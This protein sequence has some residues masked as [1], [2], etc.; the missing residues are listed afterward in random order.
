MRPIRAVSVFVASPSDVREERDALER[1]VQELNLT[2]AAGGNA[3]LE[4]V[5]W[6]THVRPGIAADPQQ[7][8]NNQA[9]SSHDIVIGIFWGRVGTPT[10]RAG[11]GTLEELEMAIARW[12]ADQTSVEVMIYF[13]EDGI[14]PFQSNAD[15]LAKLTQFRESLPKRGILYKTVAGKEFESLVRVDIARAVMTIVARNAALGDPLP[16]EP[17]AVSLTDSNPT[18]FDE[19]DGFEDLLLQSNADLEQAT[20]TIDRIGQLAVEQTANFEKH[21]AE[22][23]GPNRRQSLDGIAVGLQNYAERLVQET[24][25]LSFYQERAL[26]ALA[27]AILMASEDGAMTEKDR[28]GLL[29][30]VQQSTRTLVTFSES[31][32]TTRHILSNMPR[33][34]RSLNVSKRN[35]GNAVDSLLSKL[36]A[37]QRMQDSIEDALKTGLKLPV[38]ER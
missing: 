25:Q 24:G 13:K 12:Q 33:V 4:L 27:R 10:P 20:A 14:S 5:R 31:L 29:P 34:T 21:T 2:V 11:S 37:A 26:S 3:R 22:L 28:A 19:D 1:V 23:S 15:Q 32:K 16:A 35:A 17:P 8:I 7:T 30:I 38:G 18:Q 36:E 6:E 9:G